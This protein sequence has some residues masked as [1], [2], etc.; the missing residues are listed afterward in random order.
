MK[1]ET[2]RI[3]VLPMSQL[4]WRPLTTDNLAISVAFRDT[5]RQKIAHALSISLIS[6]KPVN[7]HVGRKFPV[8]KEGVLVTVVL[9]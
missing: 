8:E 9:R 5:L 4:I 7:K 2:L 6:M 3:Y 1:I